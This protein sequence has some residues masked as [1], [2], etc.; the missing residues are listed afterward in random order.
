MSYGLNEIKTKRIQFAYNDLVDKQSIWDLTNVIVL[1]SAGV[2]VDPNG[3][4]DPSF[5]VRLAYQE[6]DDYITD[7]SNLFAHDY[8]SCC[9]LPLGL[10]SPNDVLLH[11]GK[12]IIVRFP[13]NLPSDNMTDGTV[14][15]IFTYIEY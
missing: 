2:V 13:S 14:T 1:V 8:I 12:P 5:T 4:S 7:E 10:D 6:I 3:G 9:P 11:I 15:F